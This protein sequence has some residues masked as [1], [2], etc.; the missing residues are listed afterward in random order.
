VQQ[1][2]HVDDGGRE[3]A[4]E[5]LNIATA[6]ASGTAPAKVRRDAEIVVMTAQGTKTVDIALACNVSTRTVK[7]VRQR[8]EAPLEK[9]Q[10]LFSRTTLEMGAERQEDMIAALLDSAS[11]SSNRNQASCARVFGELAGIIGKR[12]SVHVGDVHNQLT[13]THAQHV[14]ISTRTVEESNARLA[15]LETALGLK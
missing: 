10:D 4:I 8:H 9:L 5:I 12:M 7:R 14:E 15:E 1:V 3:P 6:L 2:E 13:L 11:D